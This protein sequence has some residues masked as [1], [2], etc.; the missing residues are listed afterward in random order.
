MAAEAPLSGITVIELGHS[1]AAP[2]AGEILG[3]LGAAVVKVE[4]RD[5]DDARKWG[6]P[7]WHGVSAI[8]QSLNR[9]KCSVAVNLRDAEDRAALR[10]L[11]L[12]RADV[13]IQNLRPGTVEEYGL[14][15]ASLRRAQPRLVYCNLGA[16]GTVG[17][18]KDKPGYDPLMQAFGGLMSVT[19]E[20][21]RPPVRVGTSIMDMGA[22]MWSVIGILSALTRRAATGEGCTIDTSLFETA[23]A[24]MTYHAASYLAAGELPRRHGSGSVGIVPY[25]AYA[26]RDGYV[27]V[28]AANDKLFRGFAAVLG[29][30][31]WAEDERFRSN[32]DRVRNQDILYGL[33]EAIMATRSSAEWQEKL[34]AAGVPCAPMQTMDQILAHPQTRALGMLQE[35]A[36]GR[37][38]LF[39]PPLSFDGRRPPLRQAPPA[40]GEHTQ[41]ILGPLKA[42]DA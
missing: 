9:N 10:R 35:S 20:P 18:L 29:H 41:D 34:D 26:T 12:E 32:P 8:F 42:S 25:R 39:G 33:I 17:P 36:D 40:L 7:F 19:G 23:L 14:D 27:V 31:E 24:W 1:V 38:A 6:P 11:I 37:F 5:G 13:V 4:K 15:A 30:P 22:G 3:D 28:G 21:G 16:F 2:F